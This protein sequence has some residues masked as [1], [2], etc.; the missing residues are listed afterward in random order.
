[1]TTLRK[2]RV[3]GRALPA[4]K[5][6]RNGRPL[7]RPRT[8]CD[9]CRAARAHKTAKAQVTVSPDGPFG[10][11]RLAA[12]ETISALGAGGCLEPA[13]ASRLASLRA[14]ASALDADPGSAPLWRELRMA[15]TAL[16]LSGAASSE[17]DAYAA[18]M[19]K[20]DG[21]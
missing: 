15:E 14:I 4:P 1:M 20:L 17:V 16:R 18:L 5:V 13:D 21:G 7:G 12:E 6:S 11:N 2:C 10:P 19:D 9:E 8:T 3:C